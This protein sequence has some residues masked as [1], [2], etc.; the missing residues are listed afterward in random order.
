MCFSASASFFTAAVTG[1]A[2][3]AA[4]TRAHA[5]EDMPLASIPLVFA[6]QQSLEGLLWLDFSARPDSSA[7]TPLIYVF[8]AFAKVVWPVFIPLAV[9]LIEP[10]AARRRLLAWCSVAG[11][12]TGAFFLWS[13]SVNPH[14]AVIEGRHIAYSSE[15]Y[16]PM[17]IRILYIVATCAAPLLS[18]H[19]AVRMLGMIVSAGSVVTYIFYWEAF[20]SVWCFFAAGGSGVIVFH[21]HQ[22]REFR[23]AQRSSAS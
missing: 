17:A 2:G 20:T 15:P 10:D 6:V 23:R 12:V 16:L 18:S 5:R 1:A 21:F 14:T 13:L 22:L 19:R 7:S 8:L 3:I 9:L 4:V 11:A